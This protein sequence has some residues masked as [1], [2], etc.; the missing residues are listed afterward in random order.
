MYWSTLKIR[1]TKNCNLFI[2]GLVFFSDLLNA[3]E[4]RAHEV[5]R[6][7]VRIEHACDERDCRRAIAMA[8][9]I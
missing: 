8:E 4:L 2:D 1:Q 6:D 7:D 5:D 9:I 3:R